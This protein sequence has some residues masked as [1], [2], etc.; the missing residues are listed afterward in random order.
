MERRLAAILIADVV[1]YS[2][3]SQRDEEGT[4][5][6]FLADFKDIFEPKFAEHHGRLVKSMGDGLLV[7]FPSVVHAIRCGIEIQ[8][9]KAAKHTGIPADQRLQFRIGI[10]LGDVIIEG[11]DVHGTGV[12]IADRLQS[13]ADAGGIVISGSA[14]DQ[15]KDNVS[16]AWKVSGRRTSKTLRS[17]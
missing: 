3:L 6:Q 12:N 17:P 5:S 15:V 8:Q 10:N 7:E 11:N 13:L 4:R 2:R 9:A 1:G 14:Y 16:V